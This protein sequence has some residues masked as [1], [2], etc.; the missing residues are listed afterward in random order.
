M[1]E[2]ITRVALSRVQPE[3]QEQSEPVPAQRRAA[4]AQLVSSSCGAHP[5]E[6]CDENRWESSGELSKKRLFGCP[7]TARLVTSKPAASPEQ[8]CCIALADSPTLQVHARHQ[9]GACGACVC[10]VDSYNELGSPCER[11]CGQQ[12]G[13]SWSRV[14]LTFGQML[15]A[16]F[17]K[18]DAQVTRSNSWLNVSWHQN[19][20]ISLLLLPLLLPWWT[21]LI[22]SGVA[23]CLFIS[24]SRRCIISYQGWQ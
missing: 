2:V 14:P 5:A 18:I 24:S 17:S 19:A 7:R 21:A 20:W 22:P 12:C 16:T 23:L 13:L 15:P 9:H 1:K 6:W 10:S 4:D 3:P 11:Q 8:S